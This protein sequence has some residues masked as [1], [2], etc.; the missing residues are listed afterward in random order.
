MSLVIFLALFLPVLQEP[1]IPP[2]GI[3]DFYGLRSVTEQQVRAALQIKEGDSLSDEPKEARRR[4]EALPNVAQ[5]RLNL[6]CCETGKAILYVGIRE[7]GSASLEFRPVPQGKAQ[8]PQDVIQAGKDFQNA[9]MDA[10]LKGN[11]GEDD[12]QGHALMNDPSSR[13]VQKRFITFAARDLKLLRDVLHHSSDAEQRALA[14]E[15]IAY[16]ANKQ[17][18]VTDLVEALRDSAG[19]VRNNAMRALE[20]MAE[21]ERQPAKQRVRIPVRPFVEMLNSIEWTDHNKSSLALLKLTEKR[22]PAVLSQLR[23]QALLSLVEMAGWKSPGHANA[24][25]VVLGRVAG[26]SEQEIVEAWEHGERR[27]FIALAA[28]RTEGN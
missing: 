27:A 2:I 14:A 4:L 12:S 26:F 3:I 24:P 11:A 8:L 21:L 20:V 9:F 5:A 25:F 10:V 17:A 28:K 1:Q 22:D 7:K 23:Q 16:A 6:V 13:A 15:I 18:V 19:G